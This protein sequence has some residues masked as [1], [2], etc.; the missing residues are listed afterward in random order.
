[1]SREPLDID[2]KP[3]LVSADPY[4]GREPHVRAVDAELDRQLL[5]QARSFTS[6]ASRASLLIAAAGITLSFAGNGRAPISLVTLAGLLGLVAVACGLVAL[7]PRKG[8]EQDIEG[9]LEDV[10]NTSAAE[11]VHIVMSR[12]LD[13]RKAGGEDLFNRARW[14]RYGFVAYAACLLTV[15]VGNIVALELIR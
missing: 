4:E 13:T 8:T 1:M 11:A 15:L 2:G 12:K 14:V 9:M 10:W 3:P 6:N 5:A 7:W